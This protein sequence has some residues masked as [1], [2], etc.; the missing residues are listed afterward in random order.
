[1]RTSCCMTALIRCSAPLRVVADFLCDL[2]ARHESVNVEG[3]KEY[4]KMMRECTMS[5]P[6]SEMSYAEIFDTI[7]AAETREDYIE[8]LPQLV[9]RICELGPI[10]DVRVEKKVLDDAWEYKI[11]RE[12]MPDD[13]YE[14]IVTLLNVIGQKRWEAVSFEHNNHF[15]TVIIV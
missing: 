7:S 2:K 12:P 9:N 14:K 6:I 1:M 11:I 13:D 8:V 4:L 15:D 5:S 3:V 10:F